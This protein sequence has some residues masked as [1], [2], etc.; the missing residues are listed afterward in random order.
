MRTPGPASTPTPSRCPPTAAQRWHRTHPGVDARVPGRVPS[1]VLDRP[2]RRRTRGS[3]LGLRTRL[4]R[5]QPHPQSRRRS[6]PRQ[7]QVPQHLPATAGPPMADGPRHLEQRPPATESRRRLNALAERDPAAKLS[8][9]SSF[10][11]STAR[12]RCPASTASGHAPAID[13]EVREPARTIS[14]LSL[15]HADDTLDEGGPT[16]S[17]C[18]VS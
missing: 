12:R 15:S 7:R 6:A 16:G 4:L 11:R 8:P 5:N 18:W 2:T 14:S 13:D 17:T 3:G 9:G 1:G 10:D